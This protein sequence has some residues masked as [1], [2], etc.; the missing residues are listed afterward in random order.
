MRPISDVRERFPSI[1]FNEYYEKVFA[2]IQDTNAHINVLGEAGS[3]KSVLLRV[4]RY[5]L[6]DRNV[7]V[8]ATTGVASALLNTD[9][10][11]IKAVT[12]HSAFKIKPQDI[13]GTGNLYTEYVDPD[14]MSLIQG[15]DYLIIDECSM[16]SASL[17]DYLIEKIKYV[18]SRVG[19]RELP[20]I[21]LFGDI[22]QLPPVV[23]NEPFIRSYY[24]DFYGG[25]HYYF[26]SHAFQDHNFQ[27]ICLKKNYRQNK[28]EGFKDILNRIRVGKFT[29]N[30][31]KTLNSR[32]VD[33]CEWSADHE[34]SLRMCTTV[35]D[36]TMYNKIALDM[37]SN[38]SV[39]FKATITGNFRNTPEFKSG[40]YPEEVELKVGCPVMITKND[41]TEMKA[42]VN[43]DI[44]IL[45]D[46]DL[47]NREVKVLLSNGEEERIVTVP[48]FKTE[49]YSYSVE[50]SDDNI[51]VDTNVIGTYTNIAVK[52]CASSTVHK[53]QGLTIKGYGL[54]D[55]G[56]NKGWVPES[57]IYVALSRFCSLDHIGLC[58]PILPSD[59]KVNKEAVEFLRSI[60]EEEK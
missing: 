50:K 19:I 24:K 17:F 12:L 22:M 59:I 10:P 13:Y 21:I 35:K 37:L 2:L 15:M 55:K 36:V 38:E 8:C 1:D 32:V 60:G 23:K 30:D 4:L 53:C 33:D 54:F 51:L 41:T 31:I 9:Y 3:G 39:F 44:G 28:D 11:D 18:R 57:G 7:I 58:Y 34:D 43:G 5:A 52:V 49:V 14:T 6:S 20:R 45:M 27:T 16:L 46:C 42:F 40:N 29:D 47:A 26:N 48:D 25:N 56:G